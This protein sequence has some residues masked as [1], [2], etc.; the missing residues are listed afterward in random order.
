MN[1]GDASAN[2][3]HFWGRLSSVPGVA[4]AVRVSPDAVASG[5]AMPAHHRILRCFARLTGIVLTVLL[6]PL[7]AIDLSSWARRISSHGDWMVVQFRD[8]TMGKYAFGRAGTEDAERGA[9]LTLTVSPKTGCGADTVIVV[10]LDSP[11]ERDAIDEPSQIEMVVDDAEPAILPIQIV[12]PLGDRF[13]FLNFEGGFDPARLTGRS[14]MKV[15]MH[16]MLVARFSLRGFAAAWR[17]AQSVCRS[18]TEPRR[19]GTR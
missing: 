11:S 9:T 10:E 14:R 5:R 19:S 15:M 2:H 6:W 18:F 3:P 1:I 7:G 8:P 17:E 12:I 13:A 16:G 4:D